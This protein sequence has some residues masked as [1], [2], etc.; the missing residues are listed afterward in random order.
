MS[1]TIIIAVL[2]SGVLSAIVS[3]IFNLIQQSRKKKDENS[4]LVNVLAYDRI[5]YLGKKHIS[6]GQ[7]SHDDLEDLIR[8]WKCYHDAGGNGYLDSIMS[9]VNKLPIIN[10]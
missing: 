8:M 5:K 2:G 3:G 9:A 6:E 4:T 7:I 10:K 1:E